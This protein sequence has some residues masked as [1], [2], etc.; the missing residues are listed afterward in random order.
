M[1]LLL[2][3]EELL[4]ILKEIMLE[5]RAGYITTIDDKGFPQIRAVFNLRYKK[6]FSHEASMLEKYDN[7]FTHVYISTNTSSQKIKDI[8]RNNK[9]AIYF[10]VPEV[11][12]GIMLQGL[13]DTVEDLDFKREIWSEGSEKYYPL[14]YTDPDFTIL[15]IKANYIKAWYKGQKHAAIISD[16][17]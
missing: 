17:K 8:T 7:D 14:G 5:T 3:K 15:R 12:K 10:C 4:N 1:D 16:E 9:V 2:K 13:A 11:T 6:E